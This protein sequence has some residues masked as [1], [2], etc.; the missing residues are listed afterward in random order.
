M[1]Y[2]FR[3]AINAEIPQIWEIL[4]Q[5]IKRRK[6]DGSN[7]WQNGYP[8][9]DTILNDIEKGVGFVLADKE[10][11]IA[12]GAVLINDEPAYSNIIGQWLTN[13]DFIVVHR[14]AI[15]EAYLGQ[16]LVQ[17]LF[18]Y[19]ENYALNNNIYSI[20]VDTNFDN[21]AMLRIMDKLGYMYCGEVHFNESP[22]KAFEKVLKA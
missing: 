21:L 9:P 18:G 20:K 16:G 7:Q 3:K 15:S 13:N 22:R 12:Y 2:Q 10:T 17:K 11:I 14:V 4:Q 19:I 8:N 1:N 6:D 5:G